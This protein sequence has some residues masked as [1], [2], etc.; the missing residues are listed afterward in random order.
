MNEHEQRLIASISKSMA[1]MCVRNTT[2]EDI[3]ARGQ[4]VPPLAYA[5]GGRL[6]SRDDAASF[7]RAE[8]V[9]FRVP[10]MVQMTLLNRRDPRRL[11]KI[12]LVSYH[13]R[14]ALSDA[15]F[16]PE[17]AYTKDQP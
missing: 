15:R 6:G 9:R 12:T 16:E 3:H 13:P 10:R 8:T 1:V 7:A 14:V 2:L 17:L 5:R 11:G 4:R